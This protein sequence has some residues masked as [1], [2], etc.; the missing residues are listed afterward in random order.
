M[1]EY[2]LCGDSWYSRGEKALDAGSVIIRKFIDD[3][4]F[5]KLCVLS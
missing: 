4:K 1:F 3:L 2:V 5:S